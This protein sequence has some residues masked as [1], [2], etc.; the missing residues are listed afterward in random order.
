MDIRY[1]TALRNATAA[2]AKNKATDTQTMQDL[3]R[4]A[5]IPD[6][7]TR[8]VTAPNAAQMGVLQP[9]LARYGNLGTKLNLFA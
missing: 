7:E 4:R 6:V 3:Q 2:W 8:T 5:H 9:E 1:T